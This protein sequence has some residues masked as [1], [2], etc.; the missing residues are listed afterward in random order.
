M[1]QPLARCASPS[2]S[3]AVLQVTPVT[4]INTDYALQH[5]RQCAV[6]PDYLCY[7]LKQGHIRVLSRSSTVRALLKGHAK[8]VTDLQFA[9][10]AAA[11]GDGG[12]LASGGQD[13]QLFVWQLRL[14]TDAGAIR[15]TQ[16]LRASF[17]TPAGGWLLH[18]A[19]RMHQ[20]G[21][22]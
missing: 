18:W 14:D 22:G 9:D 8:P 12:V 10:G 2:C 5:Y 17:V 19:G 11:A 20:E 4:L 7:G 6:S 13:G 21:A 3:P 1:G 16:K 15:E